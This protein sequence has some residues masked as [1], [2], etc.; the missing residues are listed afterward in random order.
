MSTVVAN[1]RVNLSGSGDIAGADFDNYSL[2]SQSPSQITIR[3][4]R[5]GAPVMDVAVGGVLNITDSNV[6]GRITSITATQ[7]GGG[8]LVSFSNAN[9]S[10]SSIYGLANALTTSSMLAGND[11]IFGSSQ[12]DILY[13][14]SGNDYI[15][16][17][18]GDDLIAG[19]YGIDTIDGGE[20]TDTVISS[21]YYYSDRLVSY[22]GQAGLLDNNNGSDFLSNVEYVRFYDRTAA[23]SSARSFDPLSYL[24][25]NRDLAAAFGTDQTA[26]FNHYVRSGYMEPRA[27][28]FDAAGYLASNPDLGAALGPNTTAAAVHYIN[29]GRLEGRNTYFNTMAY[30]AANPDLIQA[31]GTN[32]TA[33]A[34]HYATSGRLEGRKTTFDA[35]AY[36]SRNPDLQRRLPNEIA[37]T[38]HY[39]TFGYREG[40]A[41]APLSIVTG[42]P[43]SMAAFDAPSGTLAAAI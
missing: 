36:L 29:I 35:S 34:L 32:T 23:V 9:L 11:Q 40:R 3:F 37:A 14:Y 41:T 42:R 27:T 15:S 8:P 21:Q 38:A 7:P 5:N 10:F 1:V 19:G 33:A 30:I 6:S 26:A 12:S 2:L 20:G 25:A 43:V 4:T 31:F 24:A 13:G 17:G 18:G 16:G 22:N 39:V 28:T